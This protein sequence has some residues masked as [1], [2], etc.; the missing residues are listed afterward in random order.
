MQLVEELEAQPEWNRLCRDHLA[1][2]YREAVEGNS[3]A[4]SECLER[5]LE[6]MVAETERRMILG[7]QAGII[8]TVEAAR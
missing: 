8:A 1:V 3:S 2:S 4:E 6:A 7:R 5:R